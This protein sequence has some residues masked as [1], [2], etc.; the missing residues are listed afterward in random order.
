VG[1]N[2][3]RILLQCKL[4]ASHE[5]LKAWRWQRHLDGTVGKPMEVFVGTKDNGVA[6]FVAV[7]L[8]PFPYSG[9]VVERA[10][11]RIKG[12]VCLVVLV[13]GIK[14]IARIRRWIVVL[15]RPFPSFCCQVHVRV[16][17]WVI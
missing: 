13:H 3:V 2:D 5:Q 7:A 6:I 11:G 10:T 17:F 8:E 4:D 12:Q 1:W 16:L 14:N 15:Y 9:P